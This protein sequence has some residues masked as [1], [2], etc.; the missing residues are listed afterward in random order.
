MDPISV[1]HVAP[2]VAWLASPAAG[3]VSGQ[4]LL[5]YGG[6]VAIIAAPSVEAT[7]ASAGVTWTPDE[8]AVTVGAEFAHGEH[9]GF[10]VPVTL[11]I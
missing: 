7:F 9:P 5:T 2:V 1:E 10:G 3:H 11:Q 8:L 4:V 6:K